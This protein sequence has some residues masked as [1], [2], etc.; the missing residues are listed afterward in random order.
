MIMKT[1]ESGMPDQNMWEKFFDAEKILTTLGLDMHINEEKE[2]IELTLLLF[3][4]IFTAEN[5]EV[6]IKELNS[7]DYHGDSK[8]QNE[9]LLWLDFLKKIQD[10]RKNLV[11]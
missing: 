7:F 3:G 5:I 8:E 1:R 6:Y 2:T 9:K 11:V 4:G 10:H